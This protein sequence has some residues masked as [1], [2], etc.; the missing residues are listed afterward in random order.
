MEV[1]W[2]VMGEAVMV[3]PW[4]KLRDAR[5]LVTGFVSVRVEEEV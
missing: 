4:W 2:G 3:V 1:E 5:L